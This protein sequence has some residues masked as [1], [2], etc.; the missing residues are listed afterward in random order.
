[1]PNK[2]NIKVLGVIVK[3]ADLPEVSG[4]CYFAGR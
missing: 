2:H 4:N 3:T 1:M